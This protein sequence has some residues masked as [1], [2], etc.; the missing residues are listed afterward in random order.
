MAGGVVEVRYGRLQQEV[1]ALPTSLSVQLH[2][3]RGLLTVIAPALHPRA[4]ASDAPRTAAAAP[5]RKA[6]VEGAYVKVYAR[7]SAFR[8]VCPHPR[9]VP[10]KWTDVAVPVFLHMN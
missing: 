6:P 5:T 3:E 2:A 9:P 7:S 1:T 8:E 10:A 4:D